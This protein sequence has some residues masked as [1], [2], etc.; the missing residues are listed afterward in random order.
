MSHKGLYWFTNDL[1]VQHNP[2][3]HTLAEQCEQASFVYVFDPRWIDKRNFNQ[4]YL[5]IHRL[6]LLIESLIDLQQNL[7]LQGH[8]LHIIEGP[9]E[10]VIASLCNAMHIDSLYVAHQI[11]LYEQ[12]AVAKVAHLLNSTTIEQSH[13]YTLFSPEQLEQA[14]ALPLR[15]HQALANLDASSKSRPLSHVFSQ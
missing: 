14:Q 7:A 6:R 5:G 8:Q 10:Q 13:S 9:A 11:G 15:R 12:E 4:R 1:R 3:L 2:L